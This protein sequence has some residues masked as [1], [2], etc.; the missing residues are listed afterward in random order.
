VILIFTLTFG[1]KLGWYSV[2]KDKDIDID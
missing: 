1:E 2:S